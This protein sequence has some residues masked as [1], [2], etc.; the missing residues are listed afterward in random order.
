MNR[1]SIILPDA[2]TNLCSNPSVERN[3]T[4]WTA[5][6]G[7]I[8]RSLA[9]QRRGA[10]S[11]AVTPTAGVNDG[12]YF[13]V[14]ALTSGQ[15]YTASIDFK[16]IAG[17]PYKLY[18]GSIGGAQLGT[19]TTLIATGRWQRIAVVYTAASSA[20]HRIYITKNNHASTGVF[21]MDGLQV[22]QK[23]YDTTYCDGDQ[24]GC[25][26]V[27]SAHASTSQ[28]SGQSRA[29]GRIAELEDF[30]FIVEK[31][32]GIGMPRL[33]HHVQSLALQAGAIY[34]STKVEPRLI[35]L[36]T[37]IDS[38]TENEL[39][40]ARAALIDALKLEAVGDPQPIIL[41]YSG[42]TEEVEIPCY[43]DAGLEF[44][45]HKKMLW[46]RV[47]LR[48]ICFDPFWYERGDQAAALDPGDT[49]AVEYIAARIDGQW[50]NLGP[51]AVTG[52][53]SVRAIVK[54]VDG[55]I[56]IGGD[57]T[58]WNGIANADYIA[59]YRNGAWEAVGTGAD[60][61]VHAL[62]VGPDG[63][64]YAGGAFTIMSGVTC[65]GIARYDGSSWSALGPPSSGGTVHAILMDH[66]GRL[67]VAG[68]FTNWNG[69][70]EQDYVTRWTNGA[71]ESVSSQA[72][73][74]ANVV[75]GLALGVD[76]TIYACGQHATESADVVYYEEYFNG[77]L[78]RRWQ[79]LAP[80]STTGIVYALG[81]GPGNTLFL[82]GNNTGSVIIR[83]GAWNGSAWTAMGAGLNAQ[84]RAIAVNDFGHAYYAGGFIQAGGMSIA[85]GVARWNRFI[86][87]PV[88]I[89]LPGSVIGYALMVDGDDLYVGFDTEGNASVAGVVTVNN[90]GSGFAYPRFYFKRTGGTSA[91]LESIRNETSGEELFFNLALLDGEEITI[92]LDPAKRSIVSNFRGDIAI[93]FL[94]QGTDFS[95]FAL[96]PGSNK[97]SCY[98]SQAGSPTLEALMIWRPLHLSIDGA[99]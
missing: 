77:S 12:V 71:W 78:V 82:A 95:T 33:T 25:S 57:F 43:Y 91:T 19:P 1:I 86:W 61:I 4:G 89:D 35:S 10:Y 50:T 62:F 70:V 59:R 85:G 93:R 56:Y 27:G 63:T 99:N 74:L 26:W 96:L 41:I 3:S 22:E 14:V 28:R 67:W 44:Q 81:R 20:D 51:P 48:L 68:N 13:G 69:D 88:D 60:G 37:R 73:A 66:S 8:A 17:V 72:E 9:D 75:Y 80:L 6:G 76:G 15:I 34:Q 52:P 40:N 11:L 30:D 29:G 18:F 5:V 16:G 23:A 92:D 2:T 38:N 24:T 84:G 64:I 45:D 97:I 53:A 36:V 47:A 21:Y 49:L 90:R 83:A 65:R 94:L 79:G 54:G 58:N 32:S 98:I 31:F 46:E 87:L 7:S 55:S 39:Y 42:T